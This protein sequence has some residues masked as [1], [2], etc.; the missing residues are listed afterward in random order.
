MSPTAAGPQGGLA[1]TWGEPSPSLR[2]WGR[3]AL[4][5]GWDLAATP[6]SPFQGPWQ[7]P[8]GQE[9][10]EAP[11]AWCQAPDTAPQ[12]SSLLSACGFLPPPLPLPAPGRGVPA[13]P[14]LARW[15]LRQHVAKGDVRTAGRRGHGGLWH[16][17]GSPWAGGRFQASVD[18]GNQQIPEAVL[19][20]GDNSGPSSQE[21]LMG[22][23]P[24]RGPSPPCSPADTRG[25]SLSPCGAVQAA[26]EARAQPSH[27]SPGGSCGTAAMPGVPITGGRTGHGPSSRSHGP[28][29]SHTCCL[30]PRQAALPHP[31]FGEPLPSPPGSWTLPRVKKDEELSHG[32]P[33]RPPHT[34]APEPPPQL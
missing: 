11:G 14:P 26:Q 31:P 29:P 16:V 23:W 8:G 9:K 5:R 4:Q 34:A 6:F 24:A 17:Q 1:A 2:A 30:G 15:P 19:S 21:D 7:R 10:P 20:L 32:P 12:S 18:H 13:P 33:G 25:P 22:T 28:S 3:Q 27:A